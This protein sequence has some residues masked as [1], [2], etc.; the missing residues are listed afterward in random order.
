MRP[1]FRVSL[2]GNEVT[3]ADVPLLERARQD[4]ALTQ[5]EVARRAGTSRPTLSAYEFGPVAILRSVCTR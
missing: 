1:N 3:V 4:S 5:D 2:V